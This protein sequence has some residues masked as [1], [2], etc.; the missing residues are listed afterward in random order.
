MPSLPS[1]PS[2]PTHCLS[3]AMPPF[4]CLQ[5][6]QSAFPN[7]NRPTACLFLILL[8]THP[9][10]SYPTRP[11]TAACLYSPNKNQHPA[12]TLTFC[13]HSLHFHYPLIPPPGFSL[14]SQNH[15]LCLS[16]TL[17][18]PQPLPFSYPTRTTASAFL[19]PY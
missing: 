6:T 15:S 2:R 5:N 16:L 12:F 10:F 1:R 17:L 14:P 7:C 13:T 8:E 9:S 18:E 11:T 4:P 3:L 19:L